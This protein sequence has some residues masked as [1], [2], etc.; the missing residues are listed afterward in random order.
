MKNDQIS[1][2]PYENP[3]YGNSRNKTIY[4]F[5]K[6]HDRYFILKFSKWVFMWG[7]VWGKGF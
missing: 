3:I 7:I 6:K 1:P 2:K 5:G 4:L